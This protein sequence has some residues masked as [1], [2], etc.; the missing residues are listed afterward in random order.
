MQCLWVLLIAYVLHMILFFNDTECNLG[1]QG[2]KIATA[3]I[4]KTS[5]W[6]VNIILSHIITY[7]SHAVIYS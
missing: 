3:L 7:I 5:E 2:I 4:N 6:I 1:N